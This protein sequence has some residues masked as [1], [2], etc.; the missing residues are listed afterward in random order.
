MAYAVGEGDLTER[1]RRFIEV[2]MGEAGGNAALAYRTVYGEDMSDNV[3]ASSASRLLAN[4]KVRAALDARIA[5]DPLVATRHQIQRRLTEI[6]LGRD[7]GAT[8]IDENGNRVERWGAKVSD[9]TKA[10][11]LLLKT[12]GA[13]I[14]RHELTG[15]DGGPIRLAAAHS[16]ADIEAELER[17]GFVR[18]LPAGGENG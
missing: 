2:Y 16:D 3:V 18:A 7:R 14:D 13:L 12:H 8:E 15:K 6:A 17:R 10:A 5:E 9:E 11:E 4:A 1:Q